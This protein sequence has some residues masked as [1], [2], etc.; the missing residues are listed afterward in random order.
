MAI[1]GFIKGEYEIHKSQAYCDQNHLE[2][3]EPFFT[4]HLNCLLPHVPCRLYISLPG[5]VW[6]GVESAGMLG[7]YL[8]F[9]WAEIK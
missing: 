8:N 9:T 4:A 6:R 7:C 2:V 5:F 1:E 3:P